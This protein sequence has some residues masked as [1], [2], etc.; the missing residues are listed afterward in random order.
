MA[1]WAGHGDGQA[2]DS[3]STEEQGCWSPSA[4]SNPSPR[5]LQHPGLGAGGS[6]LT[7]TAD[8]EGTANELTVSSWRKLR[9]AF[10]SL[11]SP[12]RGRGCSRAR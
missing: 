2:S 9:G 6:H 11:P 12:S 10:T 1:W 5:L 3:A 7:K 4:P 8:L